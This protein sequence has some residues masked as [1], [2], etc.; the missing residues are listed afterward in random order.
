[1]PAL[2]AHDDDFLFEVQFP[3]YEQAKESPLT[4]GNEL[5]QRFLRKLRMQS[6][7]TPQPI[8][9]TQPHPQS[10]GIGKSY[11]PEIGRTFQPVR[12]DCGNAH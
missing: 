8:V 5:L 2:H 7:F 1:M 12:R 4:A 11:Y 10:T 9:Q 6:Q 3:T